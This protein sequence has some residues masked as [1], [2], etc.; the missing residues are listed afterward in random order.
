MTLAYEKWHGAGNDFVVID[1]RE[2]DGIDRRA[3]AIRECD[4]AA[5]TG[6]DGVLFLRLDAAADPVRV[7]MR[8]VQPDGSTAAMCGNGARCAAGWAAERTGAAV[9]IVETP[10]GD[11]RADVLEGEIAVGMGTPSFEPAAIPLDRETPLIDEP[12]GD[13]R[14]TAVDTGVPH[15]VAFVEDVDDV[16]LA[17]VA[18]TIR[19][20]AVFPEGANVTVAAPDGEGYRQRTFERG[21]EGETVACGTGAVAIAAVA[22]RAG[23]LAAETPVHIAPP[24]GDLTVIVHADG[25]ATLCGPVAKEFAGEL[26]TTTA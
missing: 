3:L 22:H 18:P 7:R 24:G 11:R 25:T 2:A 16:A 12:L 14:V 5:G 15:A 9:V 4:R 17:R 19:H 21:V 23:R 10:A 13:L 8:L 6:A 20:H 1:D 26:A